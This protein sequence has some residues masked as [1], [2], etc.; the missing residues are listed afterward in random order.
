M[1]GRDVMANWRLFRYRN[2]DGSAK[3]WAVITN[4]DG[5]ISTRWGKSAACLPSVNTRQGIR[6]F[7]IERQKQAKGYVLVG[8]VDID[9]VG[10]VAFPGQN[11]IQIRNSGNPLAEADENHQAEAEQLR[12]LV[13]TLYWHID[14]KVDH[15]TCAELGSQV[16]RMIGVLEALQSDDV[17][18]ENAAGRVAQAGQVWDGW[19]QLLDLTLNQQAFSHSGQIQQA[20]G[21]MPWLLLMALK[22]KGFAGVEIGIATEHC[23]EVLADLKAEPEILTFFGTDLDSIRS[24][25][26]RLGLL[27][28]KLN[29]AQAMAGQDDSW[30]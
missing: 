3:D 28:P 15:E 23:R 18:P 29:L 22:F 5:S 14:C 9:Q 17:M 21:V 2:S 24:L 8:E 11:S 6:Q 25:A 1:I 30:F 20:H 26:E 12:S 19:Q 16:R 7:D 13:G 4:P 27:K 10:N